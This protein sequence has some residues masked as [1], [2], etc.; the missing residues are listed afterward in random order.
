MYLEKKQVL[1]Q[2]HGSETSRPFGQIMTDRLTRRTDQTVRPAHREVSLSIREEN[3]DR[4]APHRRNLQ[5]PKDKK[6]EKQKCDREIGSLRYG[7]KQR[8]KD[9]DHMPPFGYPQ[10]GGYQSDIRNP[11]NIRQIAN[12]QRFANIPRRRISV[13]RW[14]LGISLLPIFLCFFHSY[15]CNYRF[16]RCF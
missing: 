16:L 4:D 6:V 7:I 1:R 13:I 5:N 2:E 15:R 14:M 10:H 9:N 3:I 11:P 8:K 12:I